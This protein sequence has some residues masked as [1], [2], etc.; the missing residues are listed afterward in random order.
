VRGLGFDFS[1]AKTLGRCKANIQALSPSPHTAPLISPLYT[2]GLYYRHETSL[3]EVLLSDLNLIH[4]ISSTRD[5]H[6]VIIRVV[7]LRMSQYRRAEPD[8]PRR[9]QRERAPA[10]LFTQGGEYSGVHILVNVRREWTF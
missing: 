8:A 10:R 3:K 1:P 2:P 9:V 6:Y 7:Y 4:I 5:L